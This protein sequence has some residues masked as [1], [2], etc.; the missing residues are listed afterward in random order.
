MND[1]HD[2]ND[3]IKRDRRDHPRSPVRSISHQ[4]TARKCVADGVRFICSVPTAERVGAYKP[5]W[6]HLRTAVEEL[7]A[8]GNPARTHSSC[9]A[10]LARQHRAREPVWAE[11]R[12][13]Q[14]SRTHSRPVR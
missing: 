10:E 9:R 2:R 6:S 5:D 11:M 14:S 12:V 4:G 1:I 13:G 3:A 8:L 7:G